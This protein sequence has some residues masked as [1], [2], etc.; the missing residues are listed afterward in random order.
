[1]S[2]IQFIVALLIIFACAFFQ[3]SG[4]NAS[5]VELA[6]LTAGDGA[7][8]DRFGWSVSISG[9]YAIVGA[10]LDNDKGSNSGSAYIFQRTGGSWTQVDKLTAG[11]G[12]AGDWFGESV[13]ISGDY[14]I[15]GAYGDD[16]KGSAS[17]SAYVYKLKNSYYLPCF[18]GL[19]GYYTGV[20]LRNSSS[21][22]SANVSVVA[23]ENNGTTVVTEN[24]ILP[25]RGQAAFPVGY[26]SGK[27]GWI[28]VNSDQSLTGL[29]F[30]TPLS[31]GL[32]FDI[33]LIP[34]LSTTLIVPHVAQNSRWDT[35]IYICNPN[36]ISTT[37]TLTFVKADGTALTPQNYTISAMGSG[38]YALADLVQGGSYVNGSVEISATQGVAAFALY[39]NLKSGRTCYAGIRAVDPT[40]Q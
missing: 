40:G 36:A 20:A 8:D 10:Y 15:V 34:N 26:G 31:T 32:M 17:G 30:I 11:D 29:C 4:A 12:A 25:T 5:A 22:A 33:T 3:V 13:S 27:D 38:K 24:K 18:T 28:Q 35:T 39:D 1:M 19:T 6:K 37:V 21:S 14:A 7:A 2:R 9:D 16:D 23:Y